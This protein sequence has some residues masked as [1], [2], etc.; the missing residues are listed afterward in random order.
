M[1]KRTAAVAIAALLASGVPALADE[2]QAQVLAPVGTVLQRVHA[3]GAQV[4]E[5]KPDG[6]GSFAWRFREPIAPLL[7]DGRTVGRH[8]AGPS[9]EMSDGS[10]VTGKAVMKAPGGSAEDVPWLKLDATAHGGKGVLDDV[11]VVQRIATVGGNKAGPCSLEGALLA[12]PY[13]ADYVF[14]RP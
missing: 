4:Y 9:W 7:V 2:S 3:V 11:M 12:V 1:T 8:F 13:A 14:S 10:L 5:C 6:H